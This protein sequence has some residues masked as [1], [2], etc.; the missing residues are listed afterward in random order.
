M[1][2][3]SA[4]ATALLLRASMSLC[5]IRSAAKR[6]VSISDDERG[7]IACGMAVLQGDHVGLFDI[8]TRKDLRRRGHGRQLVS[9]LLHWAKENGARRA[10]LQVTLD[11]EAAVSLY[12]GLGFVETYRYW[13][14]IKKRS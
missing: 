6:L 1:A 4:V 8:V 10:Y 9:G 13:Y 2:K 7:I 12:S 3:S 14:R 11:N 5:P